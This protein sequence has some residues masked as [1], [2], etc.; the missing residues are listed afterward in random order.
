MI[1]QSRKMHI[2]QRICESICACLLL[3]TCMTLMIGVAHSS[4]NSVF[5]V[6]QKLSELGYDPGPTDG[7]W[8]AKTSNAIDLLC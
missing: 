2:M 8:G 1:C 5:Q 4:N 6:Q 7:Q 3:T